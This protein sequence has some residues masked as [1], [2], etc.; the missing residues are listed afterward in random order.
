MVEE[1]RCK[2]C[3]ATFEVAAGLR[4]RYP[5]WT[6]SRCRACHDS[7]N[8]AKGTSP[9]GTRGKR[10]LS[11][12]TRR[13]PGGRGEENLTVAEVLA[14][15]S[16]GP[17]TGVFTDGSADPN[18]GPGGWGAVY[19]IGGR[20]IDEA[21]GHERDTTNNRMELTAILHGVELV[22]KGTPATV[23]SDS[24]LAV[25]TIT[26]WAP[27][28]ARNGWR[29]KTGP[30]QNLDLVQALYERVSD[31]PEIEVLWIKAH[32]GSRWNEYADALATAY[33]RAER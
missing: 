12:R 31:R 3:G 23:Y 32:A 25:D 9:S 1:A 28:W 6:P 22:P 21:C 14:R 17:D 27:G 7:A 33:R 20:V 4:E 10:S 18:P 8:P 16:D 2:D 11:G 5:G 15:Y 30:V 29:R 19:V 26:K 24:R 13:P